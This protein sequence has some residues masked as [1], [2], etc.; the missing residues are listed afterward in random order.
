MDMRQVCSNCP[1][2]YKCEM[3]QKYMPLYPDYYCTADGRK[4]EILQ[5]RIE[6]K[7]PTTVDY[8]P[9]WEQLSF[10]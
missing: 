9:N 8:T 3:P 5:S 1:V 6:Q 7:I 10:L 2:R 4:V